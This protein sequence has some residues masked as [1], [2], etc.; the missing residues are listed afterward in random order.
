MWK[1]NRVRIKREASVLK[2]VS[3]QNL[4]IVLKSF[5]PCYV[6]SFSIFNLFILYKLAS[7][8]L[9][10]FYKLEAGFLPSL[11]RN[12]SVVELR[13]V[14]PDLI[15]MFLQNRPLKPNR[16]NY[17][18]VIRILHPDTEVV[19]FVKTHLKLLFV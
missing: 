10:S 15:T 7:E 17:V 13:L 19:Q 11:Q 5:F 9:R 6:K 8:H 3:K 18:T 4:K 14:N 16:R 1:I 2:R 12:S